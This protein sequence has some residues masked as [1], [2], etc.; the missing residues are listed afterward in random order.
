MFRKT[1]YRFVD[2]L[3][4]NSIYNASLVKDRLTHFDVRIYEN[5]CKALDYTKNISGNYLEL[6]VFSGG[7]ALVALNYY[8][9]QTN[10]DITLKKNFY[11]F[12]NFSGFDYEEA[13]SS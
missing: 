5:I 2:K 7:S 12:D 4:F 6:G 3:C 13:R 1:E 8:R 10:L 9:E 11:F